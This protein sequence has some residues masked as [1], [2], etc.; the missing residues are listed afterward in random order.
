MEINGKNVPTPN[1]IG[2]KCEQRLIFISS[3]LVKQLF[4]VLNR[5][6]EYYL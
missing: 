5:K 1:Y 6:I 3:L 4:N 2:V